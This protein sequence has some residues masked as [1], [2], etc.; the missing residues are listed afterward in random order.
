VLITVELVPAELAKKFKAGKGRS[1][2]NAHPKLPNPIGRLRC[3]ANPCYLLRELLVRHIRLLLV[4]LARHME[5]MQGPVICA[6]IF[7]ILFCLLMVVNSGCNCVIR[8][9]YFFN[10]M[11]CSGDCRV[12]H[13]FLS[14]C[15]ADTGVLACTGALFYP[16]LAIYV[17]LLSTL[18]HI[19]ALHCS[20]YRCVPYS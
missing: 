18:L 19:L 11:Q 17:L 9:Y 3:S 1:E 14:L 5:H 4:C 20:K 16:L 7:C 15:G 12:G 13:S 2:P 6:R 8:N 10:F